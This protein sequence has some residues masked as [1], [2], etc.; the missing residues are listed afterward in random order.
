MAGRVNRI[1]IGLTLKLEV[2][3]LLG[4]ESN[5]EPVERKVIELGHEEID[6]EAIKRNQKDNFLFNS[7]S[8]QRIQARNES[9]RQKYLEYN[10]NGITNI[11]ENINEDSQLSFATAEKKKLAGTI[12]TVQREGVNRRG[13]VQT[14]GLGDIKFEHIDDDGQRWEQAYQYVLISTS[15][16]DVIRANLELK[17]DFTLSSKFGIQP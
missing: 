2:Y 3:S 16:C 5:P 7:F 4:N 17:I 9:I 12:K 1:R 8:L 15:N 10:P 14:G 13:R 11:L 6:K